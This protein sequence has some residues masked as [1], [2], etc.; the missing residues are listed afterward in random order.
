MKIDLENQTFDAIQ[1]RQCG[2]C[3]LRFYR[4]E[5]S[6]DENFYE[7][8]Q[9]FDWYYMS[10]KQE[11]DFAAQYITSEDQVLEVGAGRGVFATKINAKSYVGLELSEAAAR[12]ARQDG[13]AAH[14]C[15]VEEH[16]IDH[17]NCYDVVCSFQVLE[18]IVDTRSFLESSLKC[19]KRGGKLIQSVPW[20]DGFIGTQSNNVLNMPPHHATRWTD[21]ALRKVAELFHLQVVAFGY[22]I[23]S[24][25]HIR[26]YATALIE[27]SL[28]RVLGREHR[29]LDATL[30]SLLV[31]AP[32]RGL[33]LLLEKGLQFKALRP[34]GHSVTVVYTKL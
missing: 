32:V 34:A 19:L 26:A 28:N 30:N 33:S 31:K 16:S 14:K 24:D 8:L 17:A 9:K 1:L 5:F 13:A 23:L 22:E 12:L 25:L 27:N 20:E 7:S 18:H 29:T 3:D 21:S 11:Y 2:N 4:P 6:G 10:D 15:S